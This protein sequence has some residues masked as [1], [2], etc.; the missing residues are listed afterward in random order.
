MYRRPHLPRTGILS[1]SSILFLSEAFDIEGLGSK[2]IE[3]F[4]KDNV[5]KNPADIF[6]IEQRNQPELID[7]F[8]PEV[9]NSFR[10]QNR[11]RWGKKSV[12]NLI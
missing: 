5:I 6:T 8:A 1:A 7:L 2:V 12:E 9:P 3:E 4:Y 10:L 11:R